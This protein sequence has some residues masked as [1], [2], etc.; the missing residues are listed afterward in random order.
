MTLLIKPPRF[1]LDD[2]ATIF[3]AP[4]KTILSFSFFRIPAL[5]FEEHPLL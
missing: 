1:A 3:I 4:I 5:E 2:N